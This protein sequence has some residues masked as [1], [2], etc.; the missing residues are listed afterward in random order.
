MFYPKYTM[1]LESTGEFI[2]NAKKRAGN[3]KSNYIVSIKEGE[4]EKK[5]ESFIAKLRLKD[6]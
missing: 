3:R 1:I 5:K 6:K 4:Y 2:M